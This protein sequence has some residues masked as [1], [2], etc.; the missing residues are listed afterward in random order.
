M[1][2]A[3]GLQTGQARPHGGRSS[4]SAAD[5]AGAA[6]YRMALL[7]SAIAAMSGCAKRSPY[8]EPGEST[9]PDRPNRVTYIEDGYPAGYPEPPALEVP[10]P[11]VEAAEP[12]PSVPDEVLEPAPS[13][14]WTTWNT[15]WARKGAPPD[16]ASPGNLLLPGAEYTLSIVLAD[17]R[18]PG[19]SKDRASPA[20]KDLPGSVEYLDV[21]VLLDNA[22]FGGDEPLKTAQ[23]RRVLSI[24]DGVA[25]DRVN[26]WGEVRVPLVVKDEP[27]KTGIISISVWDDARPLDE[28]QVKVRTENVDPPPFDEDDEGLPWQWSGSDGAQTPDIALHILPRG[29]AE[30]VVVMRDRDGDRDFSTW[31]VVLPAGDDRCRTFRRWYDACFAAEL[32]ETVA[33]LSGDSTALRDAFTAAG[34]TL[35]DVLVPVGSPGRDALARAL[36]DDRASTIF[37]RAFGD[38]VP[39]APLGLLAIDGRHLGLSERVEAPLPRQRYGGGS[40]CIA[41]WYI[42]APRADADP[43]IGAAIAEISEAPNAFSV[44]LVPLADSPVQPLTTAEAFLEWLTTPSPPPSAPVGLLFLAHHEVAER[45]ASRIRFGGGSA[46]STASA[47]V[48]LEVDSSF[49]ILNGCNTEGGTRASSLMRLLNESGF[50]SIVATHYPVPGAVAGDFVNCVYESLASGTDQEIA[51]G[52]LVRRAVACTAEQAPRGADAGSQGHGSLALTYQLY[53]DGALPICPFAP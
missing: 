37:V 42:A 14:T 39:R 24:R 41:S 5:F 52:E 46:I 45:D 28:F 29:K 17:G 53:G 38:R 25:G 23:L 47:R 33:R 34:Q 51:A 36:S 21:V 26:V 22:V 3:R 49:A 10:P 18:L 43:L 11:L 13:F 1:R 7:V 30:G 9:G 15:S 48:A 20:I 50:N 8:P 12:G 4:K 40:G 44:P 2:G 27:A 6:L 19:A 35:A 32:D 31:S 16:E